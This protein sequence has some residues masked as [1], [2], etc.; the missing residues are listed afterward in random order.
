MNTETPE[1]IE[2]TSDVLTDDGMTVTPTRSTTKADLFDH[3]VSW[4][5]AVVALLVVVGVGLTV[6]F[7]MGI[8]SVKDEITSTTY[9]ARGNCVA[10]KSF[11]IAN[12]GSG[13]NPAVFAKYQASHPDKTPNNIGC[14]IPFESNTKH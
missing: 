14:P 10:V 4:I 2:Y 9:D 11:M 1:T 7:G 13:E 3:S 5:V 12:Q 6:A 8:S